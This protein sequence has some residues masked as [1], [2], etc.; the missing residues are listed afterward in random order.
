MGSLF[1][2]DDSILIQQ[3]KNEGYIAVVINFYKQNVFIKIFS[4]REGIISEILNRYECKYISRHISFK[5]RLRQQGKG[6]ENN[7]VL[8]F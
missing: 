2:S 5:Y 4:V 3:G 8:G 6:R 1:H 7:L